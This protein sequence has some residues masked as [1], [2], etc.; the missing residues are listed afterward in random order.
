MLEVQPY[1][2]RY[3]NLAADPAGVTCGV[4]DFLGFHLSDDPV[5]ATGIRRQGDQINNDWITIY[6]AMAG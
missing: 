5:L 3:E 4:L 6:R 2:V 1:F